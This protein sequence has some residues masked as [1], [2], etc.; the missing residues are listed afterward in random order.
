MAYRKKS[1]LIHRT[2]PRTRRAPD[3]FDR[4]QE[5]ARSGADGRKHRAAG[6]GH[7]RRANAAD[8]RERL[9]RRLAPSS[10]AEFEKK[11]A[12][13]TK[14]V[15]IENEQRRRRQLKAQMQEEGREQRKADEELEARKRSSSTSRTGRPRGIRGSTA[16]GRFEGKAAGGGG[17][18][19]GKKKK[20]LKPIG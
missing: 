6:R 12:D 1:L 18:A 3:A 14:F 16:G 13:K 17:D 4:A 20:K 15:L 19:E 7:R 8:P 10:R 5:G 9:D 2:R 11:W